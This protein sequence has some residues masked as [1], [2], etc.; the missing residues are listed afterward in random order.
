MAKI[1][2]HQIRD[3]TMPSVPYLGLTQSGIARMPPVQADESAKDIAEMLG[4]AQ[5][6]AGLYI[7]SIDKTQT[8]EGITTAKEALIDARRAALEASPDEAVGQFDGFLETWM[9]SGVLDGLTPNARAAITNYAERTHATY[10]DTVLADASIRQAQAEEAAL[11]ALVGD[12]FEN[13]IEIIAE[14][15]TIDTIGAIGD[16]QASMGDTVHPQFGASVGTLY[17]TEDFADNAFYEYLEATNG[18]LLKVLI[19]KKDPGLTATID[20]MLKDERVRNRASLMAAHQ[21][22]KSEY[23]RD[24][25]GEANRSIVDNIHTGAGESAIS[26]PGTAI[27][28]TVATDMFISSLDAGF[29]AKEAESF[30]D[31]GGSTDYIVRSAAAT[32]PGFAKNNMIHFRSEAELETALDRIFES[33][34]F[35]GQ[36]IDREGITNRVKDHLVSAAVEDLQRG[37]Q[38]L[39]LAQA[40]GLVL[41]P[42]AIDNIIGPYMREGESRIRIQGGVY[43]D[44]TPEDWRFAMI[45]ATY[46]AS[47]HF[48][49]DTP[50]EKQNYDEFTKYITKHN[51]G[52]EETT[53]IAA[54][55]SRR[56]D[57]VDLGQLT[58]AQY[59]EGIATESSAGTVGVYQTPGDPT[60]QEIQDDIEAGIRNPDGTLADPPVQGGYL[61]PMPPGLEADYT[62][63]V[64]DLW[65]I[66]PSGRL[67]KDSMNRSADNGDVTPAHAIELGRMFDIALETR[68]YDAFFAQV[69]RWDTAPGKIASLFD[70]GHET[71]D[72]QRQSHF[73]FIGQTVTQSGQ[74]TSDQMV[75]ALDR[76]PDILSVVKD[77]AGKVTLIM[78]GNLERGEEDEE[79]SDVQRDIRRNI[80]RAVKLPATGDVWSN[81]PIAQYAPTVGL[82]VANKFSDDSGDWSNP[83]DEDIVAYLTGEEFVNDM[84][85]LQEKNGPMYA[86][87][88]TVP[89]EALTRPNTIT[90]EPIA[91][92][93]MLTG[94]YDDAAL[95]RMIGGY[96]PTSGAV[97][98]VL[99]NLSFPYPRGAPQP[100]GLVSGSVS[101]GWSVIG[102]SALDITTHRPDTIIDVS[103][104]FLVAPNE[105][106]DLQKEYLY[107]DRGTQM[108]QALYVIPV[109]AEGQPSGYIVAEVYANGML[110]PYRNGVANNGVISVDLHGQI[111]AGELAR[112]HKDL[113]VQQADFS[114]MRDTTT[115]AEVVSLD[116]AIETFAANQ[117]MLGVPETGSP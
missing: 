16:W 90:G 33:K 8:T 3:A 10:S 17:P 116:D 106:T 15:N 30:K 92:P 77:Q 96:P 76:R 26:V 36:T 68:N 61:Q 100:G 24:N 56:K 38:A 104:G 74:G 71:W 91:T 55:V 108:I 43:S 67:A 72:P 54:Q 89:I 84:R 13:A 31:A 42:Q 113:V 2:G 109:V 62:K 32:I 82:L 49:A 58:L 48:T 105:A 117:R 87:T 52:R 11:Q 27:G 85:G 53:R 12:T 70:R 25:L 114:E 78:S 59:L 98:A 14:G 66:D 88:G 4:N 83:S 63:Y 107:R 23:A 21:S 80:Q 47:S 101:T 64:A 111:E 37:S 41:T 79:F 44:W 110:Q 29:A 93:I 97:M 35:E 75:Q 6:L 34:M 1:Q 99:P 57:D 5:K 28:A 7:S 20:E 39:S 103:N 102:T 73:Q 19:A 22:N 65:E 18:E 51:L 115:R 40:Q 94:I 46:G 45:A 60:N 112:H 50:V 9:G 69:K 81:V 95:N 86:G